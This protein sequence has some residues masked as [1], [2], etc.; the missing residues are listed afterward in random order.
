ML[1]VASQGDSALQA[2]SPT[3]GTSTS[4]S[5]QTVVR[6]ALL[7]DG[8]D[9][10]SFDMASAYSA[11][12]EPARKLAD[13]RL[14]LRPPLYS[15]R[16][17]DTVP[18]M[19][20]VDAK[21]LV[22]AYG[23]RTILR[24][25]DVTIRPG[26]RVGVVGLNGA[27]KSTLARLLAGEELPD[28]G[29]VAKQRG[30]TIRYLAQEPRFEAD[31]SA[32][33]AVRSSL[34][35]WNAALERHAE[36]TRQLSA[37][38]SPD[39][40]LLQAQ[41]K[42]AEDIE[43][44]GG[45]DPTHRVQS[46]LKRLGIAHP[47]TPV[48]TMS[49]GERRRVALAQVLVAQPTLAILD[50]P[51]NHLDAE[52]IEWLEQYLLDEYRGA[53]V[54]VTHDRYLLDRVATRTLEVAEGEVSSFEGGYERYLEQKAER[55]AHAERTEKNRQNFLRTELDWL[56]RQPKA[57]GTKQKARI[58]RAEQALAQRAPKQDKVFDFELGVA[59]QG[60]V[61]LEL[62]ALTLTVG[63]QE[64][65]RHLDLIVSQGDRIG[66]IG[67]NGTGKTSLLRAIVGELEPA[68]GE[69][70]L[71]QTTKIAYF[72]QE[73]SDL[74]PERTVFDNVIGDLNQIQ[75][76][77]R[78]LK[79]H[80]YLERFGFGAREHAQKVGSLSGGERARVA[81][82]R[83]LRR[84]ANLIILDEPTN[85]LDIASLTALEQLLVDYSVS[86]LIVTHDR[87]FLDRV[88]NAI[89]AFEGDGRV[90]RYAGNYQAL[91]QRRRDNAAQT[92]TRATERNSRNKRQKQGLTWAETRELAGIL[93]RIERA[94]SR[95]QQLGEVLSSP[96]TYTDPGR[97]VA[98]LTAELEAARHE[99][100]TLTARWEELETRN[101][102]AQTAD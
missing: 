35:E 27:G 45:W 53:L 98:A 76:G 66:I 88:A 64:L 34:G 8:F 101:L 5:L 79:P 38:T 82:A 96:D 44:L 67:R 81:L 16:F 87:W 99:V 10:A 17:V 42:L 83:L 71:G 92:P 69:V 89:V 93:E 2:S 18:R 20:L 28:A 39:V 95:A 11:L 31:V 29:Q 30:A 50:E 84:S 19:S 77:E 49:G 55:L 57:R 12:R 62:R 13:H 23:S 78:T 41:A 1:T 46:S 6:R 25:V 40:A 54:L 51:T 4:Q 68:E 22:K 36:L 75:L 52:T 14:L 48:R 63:H 43:R 7:H 61:L 60:K 100:E 59:R 9:M 86:A 15:R 85:D 32:E 65:V 37:V 72:N 26:E 91:R 56:R 70:I 73:R 21:G 97:D 94:E 3:H 102:A 90:V 33:A 74:D 47:E 80:A 58:E 24:G